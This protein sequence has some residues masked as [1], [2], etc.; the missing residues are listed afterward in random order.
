VLELTS[1]TSKGNERVHPDANEVEL[2]KSVVTPQDRGTLDMVDRK[3]E[4]ECLYRGEFSKHFYV[5]ILLETTDVER[6]DNDQAY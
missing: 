4:L 6:M 2:V 5:I 3:Y 1:F